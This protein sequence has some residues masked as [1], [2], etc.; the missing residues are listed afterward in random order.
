MEYTEE[1]DIA[2]DDD[3]YAIGDD[4]DKELLDEGNDN[5]NIEYT[6]ATRCT[7]SII[8]SATPTESMILSALAES[9][10]LSAPPAESMIL[11]VLPAESIARLCPE[12]QR[13]SVPSPR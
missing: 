6:S 13:A 9:I 3:E 7:E 8:L 11:S 4:G 5:D 10:M 12:S 1:V 2:N